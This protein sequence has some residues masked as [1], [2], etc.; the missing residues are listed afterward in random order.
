MAYNGRHRF[1]C[2]PFSYAKLGCEAKGGNGLNIILHS[3]DTNIGLTTTYTYNYILGKRV[4]KYYNISIRWGKGLNGIT[5]RTKEYLIR[6]R[7]G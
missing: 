3:R 6:N 1:I 5:R 2:G 4:Q 7:Q